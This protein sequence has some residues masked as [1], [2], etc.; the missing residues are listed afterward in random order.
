[1]IIFDVGEPSRVALEE[2][3]MYETLK[4]VHERNWNKVVKR[5]SYP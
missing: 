4:E 2:K 3:A 5:R 1:M